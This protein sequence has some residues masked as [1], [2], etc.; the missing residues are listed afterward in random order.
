M[1]TEGG[2]GEQ[3]IHTAPEFGDDQQEIVSRAIGIGRRRWLA[4]LPA[5]LAVF[6][7]VYAGAALSPRMYTATATI[8]I[9][10]GREQV[11]ASDQLVT[12]AS[13]DTTQIESEV[14][15]MRSPT[16]MR[17]VVDA[18]RL[19]E[20]SEWNS[21]LAPPSGVQAVLAPL[22]RALG[23]GRR[24]S[25]EV[26]DDAREG[27][28]GA[29][30]DALADAVTIERRSN[31]FIVT[32]SATTRRPQG[33]QQIANTLVQEYL[34]SQVESQFAATERANDFLGSRVG[35]LAEEL[36]TKEREAEAFRR[37]E[38]LSQAAG[39]VAQPQTAE[40]QTMLV[41]ARADL[42]EREARLR[43][44]EALI[45]EG[46]S[47]DLIAG[48]ANSPLIT[49]LRSR[50]SNLTQQR[51][52]LEQR[53]GPRHPAVQNARNEL[54]NVQERIEAEIGRIT[55]SLRNEVEVA[56]NRLNSL[57]GNFGSMSGTMSGNDDAVVRY[58]QLL[59]EAEAA[60]AVHQS[61]LQRFQ[62][63]QGQRS[64][65]MTTATMVSQALLPTAPSSPDMGAAL[66]QA[67][68]LGLIFGLGLGLA[69]E[70]LDNTVSSTDEVERKV[71]VAAI[72]AVPRLSTAEYRALPAEQQSPALYV[73]ERPMSA[74][75]EAF[76]VMRTSILHGR[77]DQPTKVL[78]VTSALPEEG[79]TTTSVC[80]ARIAALSGQSVM[81]V[82]CDLRRRSLSEVA[83][84]AE[85]EIG[86]LDVLIGA[87]EW[88]AAVA[89]DPL[90]TVSLLANAPASFT[91]VDVFSSRAMAQLVEALRSAYDLVIL[92]CAPV[93]AVADTRLAASHADATV[94]VVRSEKTP[95]S[96]V[97]T[98]VRELRRSSVYIHGVVVNQMTAARRSGADSLYYGEA[99][100]KYY[101]N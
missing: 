31:S 84:L 36:Q 25:G 2:R 4:M 61:Y 41:A 14:Q 56:R 100:K 19:E 88:R 44:V 101:V 92:D 73:V 15:I 95:A 53:Y 54:N 59:R 96:A 37:S 51:A 49:E 90:T 26:T 1:D 23:G 30:A 97:R 74:F 29:I 48:A 76:R 38:G 5:A 9:N 85:P 40:V 27:L 3:R 80:L 13:A 79:K 47:A 43:Q 78:A 33:A 99:R 35:E 42:S 28:R 64:L 52:E 46:G 60:R 62:E 83:G 18:L 98:A 66:Q 17:R 82:D 72:A 91:P 89:R 8:S 16:T 11:I 71:G 67:L 22:L 70:F 34:D 24:A 86:L 63:V 87:V 45:R 69:I 94:V 6:A 39:G 50:E 55:T 77:L 7:V 93:L 81:V 58:R 12:Q 65:P 68:L 10:P 75:A 32:V 57:Q 21:A 20:D